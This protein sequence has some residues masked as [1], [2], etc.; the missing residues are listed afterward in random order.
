MQLVRR[1]KLMC[2]VRRWLTFGRGGMPVRRVVSCVV[3]A[4]RRSSWDRRCASCTSLEAGRRSLRTPRCRWWV[5]QD[6]PVHVP[7]TLNTT[8]ALWPH[9]AAHPPFVRRFTAFSLPGQFAPRRES[10]NRTWPIR[11][12]EF[13][14]P[15]RN[16]PGTFVPQPGRARPSIYKDVYLNPNPNR[17][18]INEYNR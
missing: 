10:A 6:R 16:A 12:L 14:S 15:E 9:H 18:P 8:P 7:L 4:W 3:R 11:C 5:P 2:C 13:R 17:N 1:R